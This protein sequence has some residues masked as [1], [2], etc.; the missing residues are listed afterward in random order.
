MLRKPALILAVG[1]TLAGFTSQTTTKGSY[2]LSRAG[3]LIFRSYPAESLRLGEQ[4]I[5]GYQITMF[6]DGNIRS[7][8]VTASSGFPRLDAATCDMILRYLSVESAKKRINGRAMRD[9]QVLWTLPGRDL[10]PPPTMSNAELAKAHSEIICRQTLQVGSL[11]RKSKLCLTRADWDRAEENARFKTEAMR[12][13]PSPS[14][15]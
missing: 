15:E 7:C 1:A 4:G 3:Q 5:V 12:G 10:P 2:Q 14:S 9:G 11:W 6:K 8:K 13:G